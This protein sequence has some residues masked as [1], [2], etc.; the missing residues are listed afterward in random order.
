MIWHSKNKTP[1]TPP[2]VS[3]L[4]CLY[5]N[6]QPMARRETFK[7]FFLRFLLNGE[8]FDSVMK[9]VDYKSIFAGKYVMIRWDLV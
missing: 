7:T 6:R 2:S 5:R 9:L 1:T 3:P 8:E 4:S